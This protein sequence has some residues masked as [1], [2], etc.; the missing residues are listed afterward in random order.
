MTSDEDLAANFDLRALS[1]DFYDDPFPT[2]R[3]LREHAPVKVLPDG[4]VFLSRYADVVAVYKDVATFSSDKR[5]EFTPKYGASPLFAH[6]TTSLV[7]NDPP[8]HTR[9]RRLIAGALTPRHVAAMEER[10]VARVDSLLDAMQA[11][12]SS[13]VIDLVESYASAIPVE[14]IGNL[15]DIPAAE[16]GPLRDWSLAILGALEPALDSAQAARGNEAVTEFVAYLEGLVARRRAA[17]GDPEVD[18]LTRLIQGEGG[19]ALAADELLHNCIFLL[20]AGHETTTNLIGNALRCLLEWPEQKALLL[21]RPELLRTA[22]E[23]F[24]RIESSN[25]LGNRITTVATELAGVRLAARTQVTLG[26]GAANR[27][28]AQFVEPDR[29]DLARHP[30]RH[31]AFGS[32]IHQCVGM[33]LARLEGKVAIGCFLQR[34]PDYRL[35]GAAVRSRRARFRGH[36]RLQVLLGV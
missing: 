20:N 30:N 6:H 31:V 4:S 5:E 1:N 35:A 12:G 33:G 19:E 27:D 32:G 2:Y 13:A 21:T 34:F 7:F 9:V 14:V 29:L 3:A 36:A 22:V 26:I 24:L 10:L 18:V 28:P 25:Q 17:P 15:L 11:R 8:R 23:E 16:R